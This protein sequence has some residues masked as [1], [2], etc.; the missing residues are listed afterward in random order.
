VPSTSLL[1][2][3]PTPSPR[4]C[5]DTVSAE[6]VRDGTPGV[7]GRFLRPTWALPSPGGDGGAIRISGTYASPRVG[8][9]GAFSSGPDPRLDPSPSSDDGGD[10]DRGEDG[11]RYVGVNGYE[12]WLAEVARRDVSGRPLSGA[13]SGRSP[14]C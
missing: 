7:R 11:W 2:T 4:N 9:A 14:L 8:D 12:V 5:D 3:V 6:R 13:G 10:P 1:T